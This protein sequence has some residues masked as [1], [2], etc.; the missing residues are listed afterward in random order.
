MNKTDE[1]MTEALQ[2]IE[3][4]GDLRALEAWRVQYL[5]RKGALTDILR[6]L[7]GL[8]IEE[9]R[10]AGA[11]ANV[12]KV[13]LENRYKEAQSALTA[14]AE[15]AIAAHEKSQIMNPATPSRRT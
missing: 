9:R 12:V 5:G 11:R 14:R 1:L 3:K 7:A 6:G 15:A 13:T 2:D 4:V 8:S 10:V